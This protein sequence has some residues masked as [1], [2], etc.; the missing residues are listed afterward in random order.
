MTPT[1]ENRACGVT[2]EIVPSRWLALVSAAFVV[3]VILVVAGPA[4][5]LGDGAGST[6]AVPCGTER[7]SV[8]GTTHSQSLPCIR[9]AGCGGGGALALG[10]GGALAVLVGCS[11]AI[12]TAVA[13]WRSRRVWSPL[14]ASRLAIGGL[15]RPPRVLLDV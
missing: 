2:L 1:P 11:A 15:F 3:C 10:I 6:C 9:D 13:A 14:P 7:S 4:A 5:A 8:Q 12:G